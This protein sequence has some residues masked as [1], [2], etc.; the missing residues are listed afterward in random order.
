MRLLI[1]ILVLFV[2]AGLVIVSFEH[3][4]SEFRIKAKVA[5]YDLI[6]E[7]ARSFDPI[8]E[9]QAIN[10]PDDLFDH[11]HHQLDGWFY[12][13]YLIDEAG[14]QYGVQLRFV[15]FGLSRG[16][17]QG[18]SEWTTNQI[19]FAHM[20]LTDVAGQ[21]SVYDEYLSRGNNR[22]AG[23]NHAPYRIWVEDWSV[24]EVG[25]GQI[26]LQ[27]ATPE[28][29]LD[30]LMTQT[31][32]VVLPEDEGTDQNQESAITAITYYAYPDNKAEGAIITPRGDFPVTGHLWHY[33]LW[34]SLNFGPVAG[35]NLFWLDLDDG[36]EIIYF[37]VQR[38]DDIFADPTKE[39][40]LAD[41]LIVVD[42]DGQVTFLSPDAVELTV[43]DTWQSPK[44]QEEYPA[45]WNLSIPEHSIDLHLKPVLDDQEVSGN[46]T[47][48]QGLVDVEGSH[49][50]RGYGEMTGSSS[51]QIWMK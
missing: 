43:L 5:D 32:P 29:G 40:L 15:R 50:G 41:Q 51:A 33:H 19:Y 8:F 34:G 12:S 31:K 7:A 1:I 25:P 27:A 48:W 24:A 21:T 37:Q 47:Y 4:N 36:Q 16:L 22:L 13:G 2:L 18:E 6:Q 49:S 20:A 26:R 42:Q 9:G 38:Q 14:H 39:I 35:W 17:R 10:F 44:S 23:I 46:L 3:A 11:P 30:L 28:I 45:E